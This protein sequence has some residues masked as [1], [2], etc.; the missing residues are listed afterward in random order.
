MKTLVYEKNNNIDFF[1]VV[2]FVSIRKRQ[3]PNAQS[4]TKPY[5]LIKRL[6]QNF[7]MLVSTYLYWKRLC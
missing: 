3:S 6:C 2:R 1:N 7:F 4:A 5:V